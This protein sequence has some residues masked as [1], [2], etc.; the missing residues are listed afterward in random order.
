M[1]EISGFNKNLNTPLNNS[2]VNRSGDVAQTGQV[3]GSQKVQR[4]LDQSAIEDANKTQKQQP[5]PTIIRRMVP[6]DIVNQLVQLGIRPTA[7]NR[8]LALKMLL[9]GL[10]LSKQNF[11]Q[12]ESLIAGLPRDENVEQA[13][14]TMLNK[15]LPSRVAVQQLAS[16]LQNNPQLAAQLNEVLAN[17]AQVQTALAGQTTT[18]SPQLATQLAAI[19]TS[20]EGY[21][22]ALPKEIK[23]KISKS[24]GFLNRAE[25]LTNMRAVR[26]LVQGVEQQAQQAQAPSANAL[27]SSLN[28]LGQQTK[29]L[30]ESLIVQAVLSKPNEREDSA[31]KEQFAYWQIPNSLTTPPKNIDLL[32]QRDS[33]DRNRTIN[34]RKTK[35]IL[36]TETPA[37]GEIAIEVDV[38]DDNLEFKFNSNDDDVRKL[39][40]AEVEVLRKKLESLNYKTK[41]VRVVKRNLDVKK[42]LI[43]TLD[44]N[45]LTRVQ[46]EV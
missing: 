7:A 31:L 16:F 23:D 28:K 1:A 14:V 36:K 26:A 9:N 12:V 17:L 27:L 20:L 8:G 24:G 21:L 3:K 2:N 19:M 42:Y 46:T 22:L 4:A 41:S 18:I 6:R 29:D 34:P 38:E 44:M 43:P 33:R 11:A 39:I 25:L 40:Q 13:A 5:I 32:V 10:E 15:G 37:L 45:S 35:L 30:T